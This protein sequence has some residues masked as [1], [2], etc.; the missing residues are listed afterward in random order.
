ML[1]IKSFIPL[2]FA[3]NLISRFVFRLKILIFLQSREFVLLVDEAIHSKGILFQVRFRKVLFFYFVLNS[4]LPKLGL[5]YRY[6]LIYNIVIHR[7]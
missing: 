6:K 4:S 3:K 7:I 5:N 2:V 1:E